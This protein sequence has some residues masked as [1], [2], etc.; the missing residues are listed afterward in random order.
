MEA[1]TLPAQP[2]LWV[3]LSYDGLRSNLAHHF[4]DIVRGTAIAKHLAEPTRTLDVQITDL[5][6]ARPPIAVPTFAQWA[7]VHYGSI[8]R[9]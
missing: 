9:H 2:S 3:V 6:Q 5:L 8:L 1:E 7:H 4:I